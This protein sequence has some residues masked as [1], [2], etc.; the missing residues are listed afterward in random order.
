MADNLRA[1]GVVV[2]ITIFVVALVISQASLW[3]AC[4]DGNLGACMMVR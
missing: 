1:L 3:A 2:A 4:L